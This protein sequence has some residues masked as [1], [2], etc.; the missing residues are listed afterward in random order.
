MPSEFSMSAVLAI[1]LAAPN[2][3]LLPLIVKKKRLLLLMV[4]AA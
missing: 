2:A 4:I 3:V 1:A